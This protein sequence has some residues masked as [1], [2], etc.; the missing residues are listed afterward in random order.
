MTENLVEHRLLACF[1]HPD[2]ESFS[3]GGTMALLANAGASVTIVSATRSEEGEISDAVFVD[4]AVLGEH[5]ET[6]LRDAMAALGVKDVRFLGYRDSGM[7]GT[8]TNAHPDALMQA[9]PH[10]AGEKIAAI[11]QDVQ[12]S[13]LI[14]FGPE[15]VYLHPDHIAIHHA[16]LAALR[17]IAEDDRAFRPSILLFYALP[18]EF[19]F[20]V[21]GREGNPFED[22]PLDEL[23]RM[24]TPLA[25]IT[26]RVDIE[27]YLPQKH[28]ALLHHRSQFGEDGPLSESDPSFAEM[29]R[30]EHFVQRALPWEFEPSVDFPLGRIER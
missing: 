15:G 25:D 18:R 4:K 24:G 12:P 29:I 14:T 9:S 26:H 28:A 30:Y 3:C 23:A 22:V 19:L 20:E 21:R 2:D 16:V 8:D 27:P 6:E 13:I 10:D 7:A 1:A 11:I 5:R 17:Q